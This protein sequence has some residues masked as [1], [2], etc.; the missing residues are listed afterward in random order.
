MNI[1]GIFLNKEI[2]TGGH[3]RYLELME[4][5]AAR[6]N[7]VLVVLNKELSYQPTNFQSI[8]IQARYVNAGFPPVA[9]L[10]RRAMFQNVRRIREKLR[11]LL[12]ERDAGVDCIL[13]HGE[14]HFLAALAAKK[15]FSAPVVFGHRAN[16][17]RESLVLRSENKGNP[18]A[19]AHALWELAKY[20][21]YERV[22]AEKAA[23][24]VFQ[25]AY[26]R[27][28]FTLRAPRAQGRT[29]VVHGNISEPRFTR[30]YEAANKSS[31]LRRIVF[32]GT[33]SPGKGV[34]YLIEAVGILAERGLRDLCCELIG[35]GEERA[36]FERDVRERGLV[37]MIVLHGRKPDPF[38]YMAAADLMVVPSLSDSFPDTVLEALHVG[39]PVIGSRVGGISEILLYDDLLFQPANPAAIADRLERCVRE[40]DFYLRLRALCAVRRDAFHFD[41]AAKWERVMAELVQERRRLQGAAPRSPSRSSGRRV[42]GPSQ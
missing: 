1:L 34:R 20:R 32:V 15:A 38:S 25:S 22:L 2:R 23:M 31:S 35:T 16:M 26:D 27:D 5:L 33:Y 37:D 41:W 36:S 12:E 7:N 24:L 11:S 30:E 6:G 10:F 28:D 8:R 13:V 42:Q 21:R 9:F 29:A 3:R 40:N 4:G 39:V 19:R 18:R 17:V 14:T